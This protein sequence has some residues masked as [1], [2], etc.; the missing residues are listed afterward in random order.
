MDFKEFTEKLK[1]LVGQC[2]SQVIDK[3]LAQIPDQNREDQYF[4]LDNLW[5]S[6]KGILEPRITYPKGKFFKVKP[7]PLTVDTLDNLKID[8]DKYLYTHTSKFYKRYYGAFT[9]NEI[10]AFV[11]GADNEIFNSCAIEFYPDDFAFQLYLYNVATDVETDIESLVYYEEVYDSGVIDNTNLL[12]VVRLTPS[13]ILFFAFNSETSGGHYRLTFFFDDR[14]SDAEIID[15]IEANPPNLDEIGNPDGDTNLNLA[16]KHIKFSFTTPSHVADDGAFEIEAI[17]AFGGHLMHI[18]QHTGNISVEGTE[19]MHFEAT[20]ADCGI[21]TMIHANTSRSLVFDKDGLKLD[22]GV[23][24][25]E[26]VDEDN[27]VSDSA[28]KLCTQQSIKKYVD[29]NAGA[30]DADLMIGVANRVWVSMLYETWNT[31][32]P[33]ATYGRLT[34]IDANDAYW[35]FKLPL[36]TNRGGKKLYIDGLKVELADADGN[37]YITTVIVYAMRYDFGT[38]ALFSDNSNKTSPASI[39]Y[40]FTAI[41]VSTL[42]QVSVLV[43]TVLTNAG[44]LDIADV[45]MRCYY[46]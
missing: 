37:D 14:L 29:D 12:T 35:L 28:T 5:H 7:D 46:E 8:K 25:T 1:G 44:D 18:H 10:K 3:R 24:V 39:T 15:L 16:N 9:G 26:I 11:K 45:S 30:S 42:S 4:G 13:T 19:L 21:L 23:Q 27:M 2:Q 43:G 40:P 32:R 34:N 17:G 38:T 36:P 20:D 41:D 33:Q 6:L 22:S 31:G